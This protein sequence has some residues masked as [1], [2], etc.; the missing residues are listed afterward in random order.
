MIVKRNRRVNLGSLDSKVKE[1][2]RVDPDS[3]GY[4]R[5]NLIFMIVDSNMRVNPDSPDGKEKKER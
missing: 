3:K 4:R 2:R 1:E 5:D